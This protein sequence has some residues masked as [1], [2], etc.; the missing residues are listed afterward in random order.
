VKALASALRVWS[1]RA[2]SLT[3]LR[4]APETSQRLGIPTAEWVLYSKHGQ[5]IWREPRGVAASYHWPQFSIHRG[6]L[7]S[8][9][10]RA[11]LSRLGADG[12]HTGHHLLRFGRSEG[13][14]VWGDFVDRVTGKPVAR[15]EA[16]VLVGMRWDTP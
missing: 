10:Y 2:R 8:M 5:Q 16:D 13:A 15:V 11:V 3:E 1:C 14:K 4:S 9:L 6:E 7:L 12:V